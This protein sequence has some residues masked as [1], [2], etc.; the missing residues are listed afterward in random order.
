MQRRVFR[1]FAVPY[2]ESVLSHK[3]QTVFDYRRQSSN[4]DVN[5]QS[6]CT[7]FSNFHSS[8]F[9]IVYFSPSSFI[10]PTFA[11]P[12]NFWPHAISPVITELS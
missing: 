2:A 12:V 7:L 3:R 6:Y 5:T 1:V 8:D 10:T 11:P 9:F 4:I